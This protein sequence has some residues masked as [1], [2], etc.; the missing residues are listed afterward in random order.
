MKITFILLIGLLSIMNS[1]T[2]EV[3]LWIKM[4]TKEDLK[5]K[6]INPSEGI[7]IYKFGL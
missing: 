4:D 2:R 7:N 3:S 5:E 6:I 1:Y